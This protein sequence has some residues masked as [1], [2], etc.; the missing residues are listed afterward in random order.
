MNSTL[1]RRLGKNIVDAVPA[2]TWLADRFHWV[3]SEP[4]SRYA[5][6]PCYDSQNSRLLHRRMTRR[7]YNL[8]WL[9]LE[10]VYGNA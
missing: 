2:R 6:R 3:S 10:R 5:F 8:F 7:T 4:F 1:R 9:S